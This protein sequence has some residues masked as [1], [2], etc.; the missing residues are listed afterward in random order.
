M[1]LVCGR[2]LGKANQTGCSNE[3]NYIHLVITATYKQNCDVHVHTYILDCNCNSTHLSAAT[4][5]QEKTEQCSTRGG[6]QGASYFHG[7]SSFHVVLKLFDVVIYLAF[8]LSSW[9]YHCQCCN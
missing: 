7:L 6:Y 5:Y 8:C 4:G 2:Y 9:Q 3:R 1:H